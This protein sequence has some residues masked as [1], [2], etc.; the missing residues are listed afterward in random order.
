MNRIFSRHQF[1]AMLV[2]ASTAVCL[3]RGGGPEGGK[4]SHA[5]AVLAN[6]TLR[7]TI[8]AGLIALLFGFATCTA[9]ADS[10]VSG[11]I[12]DNTTS[13]NSAT[14]TIGTNSDTNI[15]AIVV[16]SSTASGALSNVTVAANSAAIA[17]GDHSSS[18]IGGVT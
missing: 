13:V 6:V 14:L 12:F 18:S 9:V 4:Q 5:K 10:R 15:G 2:S 1:L 7:S 17:I 8:S 11:S 3:R 16:K